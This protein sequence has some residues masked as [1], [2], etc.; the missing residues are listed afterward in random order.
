MALN[1]RDL[2][3]ATVSDYLAEHY[4][5]A[6]RSGGHCAPRLHQALGTQEQGAVRFSFGWYNT[7]EE[8]E[9]AIAAVREVAAT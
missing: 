9:A 5:I 4:D 2:D 1:I 8:V 7:P 6:T 3:S